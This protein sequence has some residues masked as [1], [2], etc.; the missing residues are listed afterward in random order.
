[1]DDTA[2]FN[3][4][5]RYLSPTGR[6]TEFLRA[7]LYTCQRRGEEGVGFFLVSIWGLILVPWV[8]VRSRFSRM[9]VDARHR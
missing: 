1:M 8:H 7:M 5:C 4:H 3:Y 6:F 2:W 9:T